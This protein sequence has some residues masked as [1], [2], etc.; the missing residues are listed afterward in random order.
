M[1]RQSP[2][3]S[4]RVALPCHHTTEGG[5]TS[6]QRLLAQIRSPH[7]TSYGSSARK[8]MASVR[9]I[10]DRSAYDTLLVVP[11]T[12][13]RSPSARFLQSVQDTLSCRSRTSTCC[14]YIKCTTVM[15]HLPRIMCRTQRQS[16]SDEY[17]LLY[18]I[19]VSMKKKKHGQLS[20]VK[21]MFKWR[22]KTS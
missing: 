6:R 16:K 20:S 21:E 17:R 22:T 10:S 11:S 12:A 5:I 8:V 4:R 3:G 9:Y 18:G 13:L 15:A 14:I 1:R 2:P 7:H 19:R